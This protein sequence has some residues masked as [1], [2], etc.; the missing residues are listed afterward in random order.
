MESIVV[1]DMFT[2]LV[3]FMLRSVIVI[4]IL[5]ELVF[6]TIR[7]ESFTNG[8]VTD[9]GVVSIVTVLVPVSF[10]FAALS[11]EYAVNVWVP[12]DNDV[13]LAV[14]YFELFSEKATG[15]VCV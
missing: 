5:I 12:S 1:F 10:M 13:K 9:G 11:C 7:S 4:L 14:T 2:V 15:L 3:L 6:L 8:D